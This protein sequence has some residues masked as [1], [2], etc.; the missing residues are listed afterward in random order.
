MEITTTHTPEALLDAPMTKRQRA[1]ATANEFEDI[2]VRQMVQSMRKSV[3]FDG[4]DG[5]FGKGPGA[6]T[7]ED[8]FDQ[9]LAQ[10]LTSKGGVGLARAMLRSWE[11]SGW[12][13]AA[14]AESVGQDTA[15]Q[16]GRDRHLG[17]YSDVTA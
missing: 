17:G 13:D 3:S 8:W 4:G 14:P 1:E 9:N 16:S 11:Q 10:D 2:F 12:I 6:G 5:L 15:A 7:Y